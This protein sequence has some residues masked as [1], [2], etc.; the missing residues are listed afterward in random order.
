MKK[1][2]LKVGLTGGFGTGKT[3][4]GRIF[5]EL[6][7]A[8]FDADARAQRLLR[9]GTDEYIEVINIFGPGILDRRGR[10]RRK[11][12]AAEVFGRPRRL[13]R[14]N[15]VLHPPVIA[16]LERDLERGGPPIRVA[17]I[18]LLFE[19]GLQDRFDFVVAVKAKAENVRRRIIASR[20]M[21]A[22]EIKKREISQMPLPVKLRRSDFIIDNDGSLA[23]TRKQVETVWDKLRKELK[24]R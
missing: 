13:A 18:P 7:A 6:G 4:V 8:V 12:L 19:R 17:V 10:I 3:T 16:S 5:R 1:K 23:S 22:E 2:Y 15:A 20:G 24:S 11:A 9:K 14:L 21:G